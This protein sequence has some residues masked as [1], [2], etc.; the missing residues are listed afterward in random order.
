MAT[1]TLTEDPLLTLVLEDYKA[2]NLYRDGSGN[3][4]YNNSATG[5]RGGSGGKGIHPGSKFLR[6]LGGWDEVGDFV[7]KHVIPAKEVARVEEVYRAYT[8]GWSDWQLIARA[9]RTGEGRDAPR[10][11]HKNPQDRRDYYAE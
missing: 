5:P 4:R 3:W 8:G 11:T 7:Y 1:K 6:K 10:D 9:Y 2:G